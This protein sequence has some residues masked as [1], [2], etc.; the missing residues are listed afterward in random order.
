MAGPNPHL[1]HVWDVLV[2]ASGDEYHELVRLCADTL[3]RPK[4]LVRGIVVRVA[5]QQHLLGITDVG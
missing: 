3:C 5:N 2:R 1:Q 4:E